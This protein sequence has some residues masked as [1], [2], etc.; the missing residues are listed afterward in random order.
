MRAHFSQLFAFPLKFPTVPFSQ[1]HCTLTQLKKK[2]LALQCHYAS[3]SPHFFS[4]RSMVGAGE[5]GGVGVPP[6]LPHFPNEV[7]TRKITHSFSKQQPQKSFLA[8]IFFFFLSIFSHPR[9]RLLCT[10]PV[11]FT[12]GFV[13]ILADL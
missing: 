7:P 6:L 2:G 9:L 13:A 3:L 12:A 8:L 10:S 4:T 5:G 11:A 1:S